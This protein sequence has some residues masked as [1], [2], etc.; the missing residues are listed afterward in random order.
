MRYIL[1][2]FFFL[3]S[4]LIANEKIQ[5][6]SK[7][8]VSNGEEVTGSG[9]VVIFSPSYYM[10][11]KKIK[12]NKS[13]NTL[14]LNDDVS[15]L[16]NNQYFTLSNKVFIDFKN[17]TATIK[18]MTIFDTSSNIWI[19][20]KDAN[21]SKELYSFTKAK[22]SS[23]NCEAPLWSIKF[24]SGD[25]DTQDKWIN[26]YNTRLYIGKLPIFYLPW[27]GFSTDDTR[28]TGLLEPKFGISNK[29]GFLYSQSLFVAP[30]KNWDTEIT[31]QLRAKR[32]YGI[33][34]TQRLVDSYYSKLKIKTGIFVEQDDYYKEYDIKNKTHQGFNINYDRT[35]IISNNNTQDGLNISINDLNDIGYNT[36]QDI[37]NHENKLQGTK[38]TSTISYFYNQDR[39]FSNIELKYYKDTRNQ[40][41]NGIEIK[42]NDILQQLP[43]LK[44]H[45]YLASLFET[46]LLNS[47]DITISNFSRSNTDKPSATVAK[48]DTPFIYSFDTFDDFVNIELK[49]QIN[50]EFIDYK[51]RQN[52]FTNGKYIEANDVISLSTNILKPYQ[53]KI[54]TLG[55]K[56]DFLHTKTLIK[57][58]DIYINTDD[59]VALEPF[60]ITKTTNH[61]DILFNQSFYDTITKR[62]IM[63]HK[64]RQLVTLNEDKTSDKKALENDLTFYLKDGYI[65]NKIKYSNKKNKIISSITELEDKNDYFKLNLKHNQTQE[66]DE[67]DLK[68]DES[69]II[70]I[71][72]KFNRYYTAGYRQNYN[73]EDDLSS[74]K[75]YFLNINKRCWAVD[76]KFTD[77]L[78]S[79]PTITNNAVRENTIYL[80]FTMK[81][82]GEVDSAYQYN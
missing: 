42:Q 72:L 78:V 66:D 9:D 24:T 65:S 18:D 75:E 54:H 3:L 22:L 47:L 43:K 27:F 67:N 58:G 29:E 45:R 1:F 46:K 55:V 64:I 21:R 5:L 8:L 7:E 77:Q 79:A 15:V 11:A 62:Q 40:D 6:L 49:E 68:K 13:K 41:E 33:F 71:S 60:A 39:E 23:C 51:D 31:P 34:V 35:H 4:S 2:I 16:K 37:E 12:F 57:D 50:G 28:R 52:S 14:K 36:T 76:L 26:T 63:N 19:K 56:V 30:Q 70:D 53:K 69:I 59:D 61:I 25:Y 38:L 74:I 48:L 17:D 32:G 81:P 20:S 44:H 82:I 73:I 80:N 10:T